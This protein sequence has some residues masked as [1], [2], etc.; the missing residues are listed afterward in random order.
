MLLTSK[1]LGLSLCKFTRSLAFFASRGDVTSDAAQTDPGAVNRLTPVTRGDRREIRFG[2]S[3]LCR[4]DQSSDENLPIALD[5]AEFLFQ[6][7]D[8]L[9]VL[10]ERIEAG[11]VRRPA[12][13]FKVCVIVV[14]VSLGVV[15]QG[16]G[17]WA[18]ESGMSDSAADWL[19]DTGGRG[20]VGEERRGG[21]VGM[22]EEGEKGGREMLLRVATGERG[23]GGRWMCAMQ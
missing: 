13:G 16:R 3:G 7:V 11:N 4:L 10:A 18:L 21:R 5:S 17:E 12:L 22:G 14:Q 20:D 2:R 6:Q 15:D 8:L 9:E 23:C 19:D 1:E